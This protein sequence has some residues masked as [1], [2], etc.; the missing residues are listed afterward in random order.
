LTSC[1][2]RSE[3]AVCSLAA[4]GE[5]LCQAEV[6]VVIKCGDGKTTL[7]EACDDGNDIDNDACTN[8]CAL[9]TCGDGVVQVAEECDGGAANGDDQAC[10]TRCLLATC[11]DGLLFL[12]TEECDAGIAND[13]A[14]ACTEDC[15]DNVCGDGKLWAGVESCDDDNTSSGD[16]CRADCRKV[17]VC[18][19]AEVDVGEG[20]D[21]GN[22]NPADGCD[23]CAETSWAATTIIGGTAEAN[24]VA[25]SRPYGITLDLWGNLYIAD[26]GANRVRRID[27]QTGV[28]TTIAGTGTYG[29]SGDGG[30]ATSAAFRSPAAVAVD[31]LGHVYISDLENHRIRRIDAQTGIVTTVAGGGPGSGF[32]NFGG[33]GGLATSALLSV[34]YD[35]QVDGLGNLY[36]ADSGN[37]RIRK[38][39]VETGIISTV[40]GSGPSGIGGGGFSGDGGPATSARLSLPS[41]IFVDALN[42]LYIGDTMNDRVRRVDGVTGI[43]TTI[44][45]NGST[46]F[47]GDGGPATSATLNS[48]KKLAADEAGNVYVIDYSNH[49]IR[50]IDGQT[51][52]ITSVDTSG[53][54]L[55]FPEDVCLDSSGNLFIDDAAK[56]YIHRI[57]VDTG[58]LSTVAGA[59]AAGFYA[60]AG[61]ATSTLLNTRTNV[62]YQ[63]GIDGFGN[64]YTPESS[65]G[66][67]PFVG[68]SLIRKIDAQSGVI[69]QV[70]GGGSALGNGG[71][72][73]AA[74]L[75][76]VVA[77]TG[78]SVG[79]LYIA[80]TLSGYHGIRR[81][82][83]QTG[84]I[85]QLP[86][87]LL[88]P[89]GMVLDAAGNLYYVHTHRVSKFDFQTQ[90]ASVVAGNGTS[91]FS[92]DGGPAIDAQ[93]GG[94]TF[95]ALDGSGNL[96]IATM[97]RIRR[98]DAN[99][100]HI[101]T[102]A[103][104]GTA[105]FSGD[106][107]AAISANISVSGMVA[108]AVGNL[109][110][111]GTDRIRRV[112]A[113][114]G[115]IT[116]IAGNGVAAFSGDGGPAQNAQVNLPTGMV[117]DG[118]GNLFFAEMATRRVRRIDA[119]TAIITTVAGRV[120]PEGMGP[121]AQARL[122]DPQAI[123]M[124]GTKTMLAGGA[125][126]TLQ[127]YDST[128]A[129]VRVAGGRYPQPGA[130][131][132]RALYRNSAFGDVSGVA[133][134]AAL[135]KLYLSETGNHRIQAVTMVDPADVETWTMATLANHA[136]TAGFADGAAASARFRAPASLFFDA[137]ARILYVADSGNHVIRAIDVDAGTVSTVAGT[138]ETLGY[139]GDGG[140]AQSAL[141]F[142][143]SGVTRCA[144]GDL[145][146]ADTGSH[147]VRRVVIGRRLA[148]QRVSSG[149][150]ARAC[151]R[152]IRECLCNV[153]H[154]APATSG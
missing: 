84:I 67:T 152:C 88:H 106:N 57:D 133:Y 90:A 49:R 98:V 134:D 61:F 63:I 76:N 29:L 21:D 83:A 65:I 94:P 68:T 51:H 26:T 122:A 107:G 102:V 37:H 103:G 113:V 81:I 13:D 91:G 154:H 30:P 129:T 12:S 126:G 42:N 38:V 149:Y 150:A 140:P 121:V 114:T 52:V 28:M 34:P 116:T 97:N 89:F 24:G 75:M 93:V 96:Y 132:D 35:I 143:P 138:P 105:G 41:G 17:E 135:G 124:A 16:G 78:D 141:L 1:Q 80:E 130:T 64:L 45:G 115:V 31:G 110:I 43:I 2:G 144:N 142:R 125:T 86:V 58:A 54:E 18:G 40:A 109:Y 22:L 70:A 74:Q 139:Y 6:C 118:A 147:H 73:S 79:N 120:F 10:T 25:L 50:R 111:S 137:D 53:I 148:G 99:T 100:G 62:P 47:S 44:A 101:T 3:G 46:G 59:G 145:F 11:G 151:M 55:A 128:A 112:D 104:T 72:A 119:E 66:Y 27:A 153:S 4:L 9:P 7:G 123:C 108:D 136:G 71:L 117:V 32:G 82:D 48:P 92:G 131:A 5:G 14:G 8:N 60:A 146:I 20:C 33:D 85:T 56:G 39:A 77:V 87:S 36:I 127:V 69:T 95:I 23:A 15:F 19:D